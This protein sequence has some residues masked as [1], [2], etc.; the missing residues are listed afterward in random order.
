[1]PMSEENYIFPPY[2]EEIA[3]IIKKF[4]GERMETYQGN[5]IRPLWDLKGEGL[6]WS[7][8]YLYAA[9]KLEK[10]VHAVQS[11]RDKLM[12]YGTIIWPDDKH[13]LPIFSAFWAKSPPDNLTQR[14]LCAAYPCTLQ[15]VVWNQV[16]G[17]AAHDYKTESIP[18]ILFEPPDNLHSPSSTLLLISHCATAAQS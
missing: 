11:Y 14:K 8:K 3:T 5:D 1:M 7:F 6:N 12:V 17:E 9:P 2:D 4:G 16:S 13:A 18:I 15:P 10:I